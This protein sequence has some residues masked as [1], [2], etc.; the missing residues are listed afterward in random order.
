MTRPD[1]VG[2]VP[3]VAA[4]VCPHPP[5]LV[6]QI[7]VGAAG[8][9]DALRSACD[10]A[11][12]LLA[13]AAVDSIIVVGADTQTVRRKPPFG[14]TFSP[15]GI[16]LSVGDP[17]AD[18]LPL[19]L[20]VGAW[21]LPRADGFVSVA[22]TASADQCAALGEVLAGQRRMGLLVM[23]DGS[24]RRGEKAPGYADPRAESFDRTVGS[25]LAK[26]D[27]DAL[28]AIDPAL[29][30]E[31]LAAGRA[32][33]QVLAGARRVSEPPA[34]SELLFDDAPYGVAYLVASW[35]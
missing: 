22:A 35:R 32:P 24:A 9:L 31:L 30:A 4:A 19:S 13:A 12:A 11:V 8:E 34:T 25:A 5:L 16:D 21:L 23:A 17:A 29:A 28:L 15:W 20:L 33:W 2:S 18:P 1:T 6:P 3:L 10:M 27:A 26:A 7:A 14:G